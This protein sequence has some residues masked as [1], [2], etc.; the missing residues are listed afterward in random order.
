MV[1]LAEKKSVAIDIRPATKI[2]PKKIS[3]IISF[4]YLIVLAT[5]LLIGGVFLWRKYVDL[6]SSKNISDSEW[7]WLYGLG[8]FSIF[9]YGVMWLCCWLMFEATRKYAAISMSK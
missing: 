3:I 5:M 8:G 4:V 6:V 2:I 7:I 1:Y 9:C